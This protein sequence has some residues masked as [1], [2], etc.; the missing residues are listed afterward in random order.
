MLAKPHIPIF[1]IDKKN[2]EILVRKKKY[3]KQYF[4]F[5]VEFCGPSACLP[6]IFNFKGI[7]NYSIPEAERCFANLVPA[8]NHLFISCK[9][10][11]KFILYPNFSS[12]LIQN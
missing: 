1:P 12:H 8:F 5:P 9:F 11:I 3:K 10:F 6:C 2:S 4:T 7:K